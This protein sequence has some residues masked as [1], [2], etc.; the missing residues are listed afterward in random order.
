MPTWL[1]NE[2]G[3]F[4]KYL[5]EQLKSGVANWKHT[6]GRAGPGMTAMTLS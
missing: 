3:D 1:I 4:D 5:D 2:R 6:G